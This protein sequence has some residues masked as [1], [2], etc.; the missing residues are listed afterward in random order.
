[1]Y[2]FVYKHVLNQ[3][4]FSPAVALWDSIPPKTKQGGLCIA[5]S[6]TPGWRVL[7]STLKP[8]RGEDRKIMLK[9][10]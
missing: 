8:C 1:M 10:T 9:L 3:I 2:E 7:R 6:M 5:Q 4:P